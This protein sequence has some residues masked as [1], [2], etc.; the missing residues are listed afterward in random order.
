MTEKQI[1]NLYKFIRANKENV[2]SATGRV[3][4]Y[5]GSLLS[6]TRVKVHLSEVV[7]ECGFGRDKRTLDRNSLAKEV[8]Q[9]EIHFRVSK[10]NFVSFGC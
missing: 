8:R 6:I 2:K 9:G 1:R 7:I 4:F 3:S 5:G 10:H